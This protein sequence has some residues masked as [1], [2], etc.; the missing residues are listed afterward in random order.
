MKLIINAD[1]FGLSTPVNKAIDICVK[2]GWIQRTTLMINMPQT[3]EAVK[4]AKQNKY[5]NKV[6]LHINLIEGIPLTDKIKQTSLCND[7]G[8]FNGLFFKI[9]SHR[10][11]LKKDEREAVKEEVEAQIKRYISYG[12]ET[13][14]MDSH[15]HS[16]VNMSVFFTILNLA[17]KYNFKSIRLSRNLPVSEIKGMK[18]IYKKF[19]NQKIIQFNKSYFCGNTRQFF[20][21]KG[22]CEKENINKTKFEDSIVE[23]MVHPTAYNG[24]I[25]DN[26]THMRLFD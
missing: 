18:N 6:G 13:I 12:F 20:G 16:H 9:T 2:N 17:Q 22:D 1:D 10:F 3:K 23:M 8:E 25:I 15:Q 4:L 14:H 11:F 19:I 26:F 21:S 5:M 7:H 24:K